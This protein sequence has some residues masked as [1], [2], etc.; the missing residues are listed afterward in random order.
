MIKC[1]GT[2]SGLNVTIKGD[3]DLLLVELAAL[4]RTIRLSLENESSQE[5]AFMKIRESGEI[6]FLD[7]DDFT[8]KM[9]ERL[10][11]AVR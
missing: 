4:I 1:S 9:T 6:A 3:N 5:D 7:D 2:P 11:A 10:E 8:E